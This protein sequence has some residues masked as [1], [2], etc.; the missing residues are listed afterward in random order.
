M[1]SLGAQALLTVSHV[2][3][4]SWG[5]LPFLPHLLNGQH[6]SAL[7]DGTWAPGTVE[8][9]EHSRLAHFPTNGDM[10]ATTPPHSARPRGG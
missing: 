9:E 7:T 3:Q 2:L 8:F 6:V 4:G 5:S 10:C 1:L